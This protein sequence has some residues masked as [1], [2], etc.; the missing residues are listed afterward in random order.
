MKKNLTIA[1]LLLA[2]A[3]L[4]AQN[5]SLGAGTGAFAFG[6]FVRRTMRGPASPDQPAVTSTLTLSA[7]VRPGLAVDLQRDFGERWGLRFEG[8][9][10]RSPLSIEDS[11]GD[12]A[13]I[14][15]GDL[16]VSTFMVPIV[17]RINRGGALRFHVLAG[18]AYAIYKPHGPQ[19][20]DASITVFEGSRSEWGGAAGL[21][22]AWRWS[23]R[24]AIE[25]EI[26]DIVTASPF[27][28]HDFPN[29][30]GLKIPKPHNVHTKLG[31]RYRF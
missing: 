29:T 15:A 10:T 31:V 30:P 6:D 12:E 17:F 23:N 1:L 2:A 28:R 4:S 8:A 27:H 5:W 21:G 3:P 20:A 14:Q 7:A 9:F 24:F 25:G 13:T 19:N 16:D 18:P 11:H 22:A 26:T